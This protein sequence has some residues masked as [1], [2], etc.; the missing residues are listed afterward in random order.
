MEEFA[1]CWEGL[2]DPRT[3][4]ATR[5]DLRDLLMIALCSVIRGGENVMDTAAF[6]KAKEPSL[7]GFLRLANGV[8][9]HD[10]MVTHSRFAPR[11]ISA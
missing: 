5:H 11:C 2:K 8:P 10:T 7:R 3:G 6:A 9:S 4:Y 1:A